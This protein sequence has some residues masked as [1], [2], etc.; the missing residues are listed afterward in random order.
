MTLKFERQDGQC[1]VLMTGDLDLATV[2]SVKAEVATQLEEGYL[3]FLLDFSMVEHVD[4]TGLGFLVWLHKQTEGKGAMCLC[5]GKPHFR[6]VLDLTGLGTLFT[7]VDERSEG[8]AFLAAAA[9]R[10]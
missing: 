7:M 9:A 2:P 8:E 5:C 1:V 10:S 3:R 4:T 6:K